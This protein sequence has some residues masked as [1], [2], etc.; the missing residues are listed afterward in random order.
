LDIKDQI[1]TESYAIYC[2]DCIE[3]MKDIPRE[4]EKILSKASR[5]G[6]EKV[7]D[8][9]RQIV[10]VETGNLR[11][12]LDIKK[13]KIKKPQAEGWKVYA[14]AKYAFAV[15]SGTSNTEAQPFI[16]PAYDQ[17]ERQISETISD[18]IGDEIE[19]V[20]GR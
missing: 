19:K 7:L 8:T 9:A 13:L 17:N 15:E 12:S 18:I 5:V 11:N 2:G 1:I 4:A 16:R 3:V 20:W 6:A 10:K 14:K